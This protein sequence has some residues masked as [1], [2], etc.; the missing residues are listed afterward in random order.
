MELRNIYRQIPDDL[1]NEV[2]E[3]LVEGNNIKIERIISSGHSSP[4]N[5]WYDQEENE[6]VLVLKGSASIAFED[7]VE[8]NLEEG[9]YINIAAHKRHKVTSTDPSVETIWLA[10][11]Y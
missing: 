9:D 8:I 6:W 4:Y 2:F 3:T 1:S 10:V 7:A 11:F 5:D